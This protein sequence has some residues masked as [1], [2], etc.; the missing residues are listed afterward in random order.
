MDGPRETAQPMSVLTRTGLVFVVKD[1]GSGT[2]LLALE[3]C[4][5]T[6][7]THDF[8]KSFQLCKPALSWKCEY[9]YLLQM[10]EE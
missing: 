3:F 4:A 9:T 8:G 1:L 2:R 10:F 6:R 7:R 5:P